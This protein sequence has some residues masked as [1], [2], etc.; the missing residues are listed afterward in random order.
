M[1]KQLSVFSGSLLDFDGLY[2]RVNGPIFMH[3]LRLGQS[4]PVNKC[5]MSNDVPR[6]CSVFL[7][8]SRK[9]IGTEGRGLE[10][11]RVICVY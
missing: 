4:N 11:S 6:K 9:E 10:A 1:F 5:S 8:L 3:K 7:V 2:T